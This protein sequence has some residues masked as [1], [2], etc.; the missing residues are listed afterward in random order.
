M[1]HSSKLF[2]VEISDPLKVAV[3][4]VTKI[5]TKFVIHCVLAELTSEVKD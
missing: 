5:K 4:F 2:T 3:N 1:K